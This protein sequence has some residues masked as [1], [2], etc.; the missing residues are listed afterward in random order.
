[1]LDGKQGKKKHLDLKKQM[2]SPQIKIHTFTHTQKSE[3]KRISLVLCD[4][5]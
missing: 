4:G 3:E 1:M 5:P 2:Y